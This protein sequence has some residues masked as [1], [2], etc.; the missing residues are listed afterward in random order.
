MGGGFWVSAFFLVFYGGHMSKIEIINRALLKLG[1]PPV[2]SLNDAAFGKTY[3]LIYDDLKNLLLSSYPWGFALTYKHLE[4]REEKFFDKC[5][6]QLPF[7]CLLLVG[8]RHAVSGGRAKGIH[9]S[10]LQDFEIADNCLVCDE[11]KGVDVIYVRK[12][13][14]DAA[15]SFLFR[16][17]LAAKLAAEFSMRLKHSVN[18]RQVFENEFYNLIKRAELN[19]E[20]VK[21]TEIMPD[22]SWVSIREVW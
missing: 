22:S 9:Q 20:I 8:L 19:N 3:E 13:D 6:Y 10:A 21:S 11:E 7:D 4:R 5:M 15:F 16:E 1:E 2:S 12:I 18:F 14:D 17:A